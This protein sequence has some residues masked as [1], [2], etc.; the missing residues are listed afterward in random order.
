MCDDVCVCSLSCVTKCDVDMWSSMGIHFG[1]SFIYSTDASIYSFAQT[2]SAHEATVAGHLATLFDYILL[3]YFSNFTLNFIFDLKN[4]VLQ[5][6]M[7]C[8]SKK[9]IQVKP[10]NFLKNVNQLETRGERKGKYRNDKK[11]RRCTSSY[12]TILDSVG[13]SS[14]Y[15]TS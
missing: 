11:D 9:G 15:G 8:G 12:Y 1:Y 3:T 14:R 2:G 4:E 13:G 7:K 6:K 10:F 5:N